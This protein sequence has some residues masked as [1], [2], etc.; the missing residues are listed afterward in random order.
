MRVPDRPTTRDGTHTIDPITGEFRPRTL[1]DKVRADLAQA[2]ADWRA[3]GCRPHF[4]VDSDNNIHDLTQEPDMTAKDRHDELVALLTEIRDRLPQPKRGEAFVEMNPAAVG[5]NLRHWKPGPHILGGDCPCGPEKVPHEPTPADD[6]PG[7]PVEP[8]DLRAGDRVEFTW[9]GDER[10]TCALVSDLG[11][12]VL[13]SDAPHSK[14]Y[15]PNVV[16]RGK[17]DVGISDVR[18]IE[19]APREDED[20]D[21]ALAKV[22]YE[23]PFAADSETLVGWRHL[24]GVLR[25][26]WLDVARAAREQ[27][28]AE[29][30]RKVERATDDRYDRALDRAEK[31]EAK[32]V[33]Y[34]ERYECSHATNMAAQSALVRAEAERDAL[35]ERLDALRADLR[36]DRLMSPTILYRDDERAAAIERGESDA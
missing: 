10:I 16:Y 3:S 25:E 5:H 2:L 20:P 8:S 27:I 35:R 9:Q 32:A 33:D 13:V 30:L 28:E 4:F 15:L 23:T 14:G 17:W 24:D 18:L 11:G 6:L 31:A 12:D 26:H 22:L 19:R 36:A 1:S 29:V 34:E 7:E 21:E